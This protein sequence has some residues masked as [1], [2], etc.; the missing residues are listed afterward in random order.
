MTLKEQVN[1]RLP[2]IISGPTCMW[3][4]P[5]N[6]RFRGTRCGACHHRWWQGD[7][8]PEPCLWPE[9]DCVGPGPLREMSAPIAV[10]DV[11]PP[12]DDTLAKWSANVPMPA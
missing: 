2:F 10:L 5:I 7:L 12:G 3:T 4:A 8:N 11:G 1:H 6:I 9:G